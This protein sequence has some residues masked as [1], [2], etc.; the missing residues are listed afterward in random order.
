MPSA[1]KAS[2]KFVG[3]TSTAKVAEPSPTLKR[4]RRTCRAP[5][6]RAACSKENPPAKPGVNATSRRS[7]DTGTQGCSGARCQRPSACIR[8]TRGAL[9]SATMPVNSK[10]SSCASPQL[11]SAASATALRG[12]G[13]RNSCACSA[14]TGHGNFPRHARHQSPG[15]AR[16]TTATCPIRTPRRTPSDSAGGTSMPRN[17]TTICA[18]AP[19]SARAGCQYQSAARTNTGRPKACTSPASMRCRSASGRSIHAPVPAKR[20]Q[21]TSTAD[22]AQTARRQ[23]GRCP[24][25]PE[26]VSTVGGAMAGSMARFYSTAEGDSVPSVALALVE[27]QIGAGKQDGGVGGISTTT[28]AGHTEAGGECHPGTIRCTH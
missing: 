14:M 12:G 15:A 2:R 7:A 10:R 13:S 27:R 18:G 8:S 11:S 20:P 22:N 3:S 1:G 9:T 25:C 26:A 19:P 23:H 21:T 5:S 28:P 17:C 6:C 24:L 16:S 4:A